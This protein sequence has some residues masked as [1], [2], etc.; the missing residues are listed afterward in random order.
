MENRTGV[1]CM[2]VCCEHRSPYPIDPVP[3]CANP[4]R[5]SPDLLCRLVL[6]NRS[7]RCPT[8]LF[9][10]IGPR[11]SVISIDTLAT[12]GRS[13]QWLGTY[14][15]GVWESTTTAC[16]FDSGMCTSMSHSCSPCRA[17]PLIEDH[18]AYFEKPDVCS[19]C[20]AGHCT[21]KSRDIECSM[22]GG[23]A[24]RDNYDSGPLSA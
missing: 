9:R 19:T 13:R 20:S 12:L 10:A 3:V 15:K 4:A 17:L 6:G 24:L 16:S 21:D 23:M 2:S 18:H 1:Q 7:L 14:P 11:T 22:S 5:P 8:E